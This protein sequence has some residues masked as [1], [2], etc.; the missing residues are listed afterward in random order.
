M[1]G[2]QEDKPVN[3]LS[4]DQESLLSKATESGDVEDWDALKELVKS[5]ITA[6]VAEYARRGP[7]PLI[8]RSN[9]PST[10]DGLVILPP[11]PRANSPKFGLTRTLPS[12]MTEAEAKEMLDNILTMLENFSD[13]PPFTIKRIC[14]LVLSPREHY[15]TVGK[16]LRGLEKTLL[17][18]SSPKTFDISS[19]DSETSVYTALGM[20]GVLKTVSTPIFT[21]ITFLHDD[22]R[23]RS[24][25]PP[26]SPLRLHNSLTVSDPH[27][28]EPKGLGLV[29]ELDTPDPGHMASEP[30]P[31][32]VTTSSEPPTPKSEGTALPS[33]NDRF[34]KAED[35]SE[36][37]TQGEEVAQ[38]VKGEDAEVESMVLSREDQ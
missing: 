34:V 13:A 36:G 2:E 38:D 6:N 23:Q 18:T 9:Q 22:A 37:D 15:R 35:S 20:D 8:E 16:Y 30:K 4:E 31:L 3:L 19:E 27:A 7:D 29:D 5:Q 24:R 11:K 33:L 12:N 14:E 26:L 1:N 10:T 28:E 17:V 21:P 25:S 32:T